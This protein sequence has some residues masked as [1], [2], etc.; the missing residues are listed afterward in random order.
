MTASHESD[1]PTVSGGEAVVSVLRE[2]GVDTA[3]SVPGESFLGVLVAMEHDPGFRAVT[4]RHEGGAAFMALAHASL[5]RLPT[6]C[7]G[8]RAVGAT[9]L[10]IGLHSA[11]QDSV[12]LI[13][14]VGQ[15]GISSRY[16][17][18]FQEADL[19]QMFRPLVKLAVEVPSADR[20]AELTAMA[21]RT[22]VSGRPGPVVVIVPE[23]L[24]SEDVPTPDIGP[25]R[26]PRPGPDLAA[27]AAALSMTRAAARPVLVVG[28]G[29]VAASATESCV[30]VAEAE[31][32]PVV[33]AW[34]RPDAFPNDHRL[35]LGLGGLRSPTVVREG[36]A[37]AD[38]IVAI[39][40]RLDEFTL[41]RYALPAP[42]TRLI[43]VDLAAEDL[44]GHRIAQIAAHS[45][46]RLFL[47]AWLAAAERDP[48][49]PELRQSRRAENDR[50]RAAWERITN[51]GRGSA[52]EGYADQ[53]R[54]AGHL[55]RLLAPDTITVV[56]G[57]NFDGWL[58]RFLCWKRPG[59]YLAPT[60]GAMGSAIPG[61]IGAALA[62]PGAEIV[63]LVGDGGYGMTGMEIETAVRE[64][65][66]FTVIVYDNEQ[67]GT[68]RMNQQ[69]MYP[70]TPVGAR[71][72]PIDFA[73]NARSLG[74]RGV[75][76]SDDRDFPDAFEEARR[77]GTV[78]VIH[79]R[80]D[81]DQVFVGD[82]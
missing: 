5:R 53:Q 8:T 9:N 15:V 17:E 1:V 14:I 61:A 39:G 52:R 74:A 34:R 49:S 31:E 82:E 56:D 19:A 60:S 70:D 67:L 76:L 41:G 12:P 37:R 81:P 26:A 2:A 3:F 30:T 7:M 63:A 38:L 10:A 69:F 50:D 11:R 73:A 24:L 6:V 55:R 62:R 29:L 20:L 72:G 36:L 71:L 4:A 22:A 47:Q 13:A 54:I 42:G 48:L 44:G 79:L 32:L 40:V 58:S 66:A 65:L 28:G 43:H 33:A 51:P 64:G 35:Y 78:S 45:D 77:S 23:N 57:G 18:A 21:A 68:I 27:V 16:R 59:T 75:T 25:I 80:V 46:P